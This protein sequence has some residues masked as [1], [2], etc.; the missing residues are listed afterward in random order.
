MIQGAH[1]L[2]PY[3]EKIFDFELEISCCELTFLNENMSLAIVKT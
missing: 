2:C 3:N 1:V